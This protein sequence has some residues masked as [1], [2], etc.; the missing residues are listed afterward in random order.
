[1]SKANTVKADSKSES[2]PV[3]DGTSL[4][5]LDPWLE[6]YAHQLRD[7]YDHYKYVR[8]KIDQTGG[9]LGP[10]SQ[11]HH[12]LGFTRG[13][14]MGKQGVWYREWAPAA[15]SLRLIGDFNGWDR[16]ASMMNNDQFG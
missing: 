8:A 1:M 16:G 14:A 4:I 9:L 15:L 3:N 7:R 6:P 2:N 13:E 12:L 11:G 5:A 10:I